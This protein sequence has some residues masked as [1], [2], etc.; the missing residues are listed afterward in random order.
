VIKRLRAAHTE[1]ELAEIYRHPYQHHVWPD[2]VQRVNRTIEIAKSVQGVRS[3]ADL[4]AGDAVIIRS[5]NLD[6]S[7]IGDYSGSYD[8]KGA[9]ED[10]IHTIQAVDLFICSETIEHLDDPI[11]VL[12]NIRAKTKYLLLSTPN[13]RF[14]DN[15]GAHYW[16]WDE[17]GVR[18]ILGES[19]FTPISVEILRP[20][21]GSYYDYQI[22]L[23]E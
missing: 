14:D 16:A 23:C 22:W 20:G 10:T 18:E 17:D 3:A 13:A 4:S 1:D 7:Y 21:E 15:N 5:L 9:I 2:H 12:K 11:S 8:I 19:G 6:D